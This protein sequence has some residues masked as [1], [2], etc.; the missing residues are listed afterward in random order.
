LEL[1]EPTRPTARRPREHRC[2]N[3]AYRFEAAWTKAGYP[4]EPPIE[5]AH[6]VR[7]MGPVR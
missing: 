6:A 1:L 3:V 4:I 5:Q 2:Q 7:E